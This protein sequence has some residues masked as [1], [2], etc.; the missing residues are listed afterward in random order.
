MENKI[1]IM[2][3]FFPF[4]VT[5][6][7]DEQAL[8]AA[9]QVRQAAYARHLPEVAKTMVAPESWDTLPGAAVLVARSKLDGSPLG[10]MRMHSNEFAPLPLEQSFQLP[11][12]FAGLRLVEATRFAI[13]ADGASPVVKMALLK[14]SLLY[15]L[16]V[17]ADRMVI[18]ARAPLDRM[19]E[20][21]LFKDVDAAAGFVPMNHVGGLPHRVMWQGSGS[22]RANMEAARHPLLHFLHEMD[23]PDIMVAGGTLPANAVQSGELVVDPA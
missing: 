11:E 21:L 14:A 4:T 3:E 19:Y 20:R 10:T 6:A 17:N 15:T 8:R 7:R 13:A 5:I 22:A 12:E 18:T 23:H 1:S 2:R 16:A 9:V